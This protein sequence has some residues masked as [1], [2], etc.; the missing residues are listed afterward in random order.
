MSNY[1]GLVSADGSVASLSS[2]QKVI[3]VSSWMVKVIE[4]PCLI[5]KA[6]EVCP[7]VVKVVEVSSQ[8]VECKMWAK[9]LIMVLS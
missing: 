9:H 5:V 4:L 7:L 6:I 1:G 3:K 8:F 2:S